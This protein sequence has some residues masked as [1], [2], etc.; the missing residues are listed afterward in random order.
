MA[1]LPTVSVWHRRKCT[2][3]IYMRLSRVPFR[4]RQLAV[5]T[6]APFFNC[7]KHSVTPHCTFG[8]VI[9]RCVCKVC[10]YGVFVKCDCTL[11]LY[12]ATASG[13]SIVSIAKCKLLGVIT[14][15]PFLHTIKTTHHK[16]HTITQPVFSP[17]YE[18]C[19]VLTS[20]LIRRLCTGDAL[21]TCG[22]TVGKVMTK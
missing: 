11:C 12:M 2:C 1:F 8:R 18:I 6:C 5:I 3:S 7:T 16:D 4:C 22:L 19:C 20:L 9:V 14:F 13:D 21:A 15:A 17:M 10:L